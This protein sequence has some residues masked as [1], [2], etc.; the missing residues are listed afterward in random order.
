MSS[1]QGALQQLIFVMGDPAAASE[2]CHSYGTACAPRLS[3]LLSPGDLSPPAWPEVWLRAA[4]KSW[5]C[6]TG[7]LC[8]VTC[9][10]CKDQARG[11][12]EP[13]RT[14]VSALS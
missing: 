3:R 12:G 6:W 10:E 13:G 11:L 14:Q 9:S 7:L 8:G 4:A 5:G 2:H 1:P